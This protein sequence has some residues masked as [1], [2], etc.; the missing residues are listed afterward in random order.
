MS[1]RRVLLS[2]PGALTAGHQLVELGA[3]SGV[4]GQRHVGL[5]P[6]A[7]LSLL[8]D[9]VWV[10]AAL[11]DRGRWERAMAVGAG[12][13][14][15]AP[16]LH[17]TLFPWRLRFG[18]PVL[19][20][21]EGLRGPPLVGYVALLYAWAG[22]GVL[23]LIAVPRRRRRWALLGVGLAAAFRQL[24]ADHAGWIAAESTRNAQWWN[25]AWRK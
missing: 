3:G 24:A 12:T 6:A 19:V 23:A 21:A 20:E 16:V 14:M 7:S 2:L 18:V 4:I 13:A 22:A 5:V 15:A 25:R 1:S 17:Y 9:A 11:R 8:T 10:A